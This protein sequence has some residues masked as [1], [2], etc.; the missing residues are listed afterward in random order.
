M[1][2]ANGISEPGP[3]KAVRLEVVAFPSREEA[4]FDNLVEVDKA[5]H[6]GHA[7]LLGPI[8]RHFRQLE[9]RN[10][11]RRRPAEATG[12]GLCGLPRS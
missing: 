9:N 7:A 1:L 2:V 12:E 6:H 8:I 10:A 4:T 3:L 5:A 11:G